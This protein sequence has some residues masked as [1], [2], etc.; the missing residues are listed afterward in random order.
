[1]RQLERVRSER[2]PQQPDKLISRDGRHAT[3]R[4]ERREG[5]LARYDREQQN[6]R[7]DEHDRHRV[8]G[9]S[10]AVDASDPAGQRRTPSRATARSREK[11]TRAMLVCVMRS[12]RKRDGQKRRSFVSRNEH[13]RIGKKTGVL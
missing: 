1:M 3:C 4:Y 9:L 7:K 8:P 13:F 12:D 2:K 6:R 10:M 5:D 11:A